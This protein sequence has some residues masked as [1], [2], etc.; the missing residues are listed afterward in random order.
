MSVD[1]HKS[2]IFSRLT[3]ENKGDTNNIVVRS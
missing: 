2:K 1:I 3:P